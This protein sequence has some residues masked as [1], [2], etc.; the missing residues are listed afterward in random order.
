MNR[1]EQG[2]VMPLE[3]RCLYPGRWIIEGY[4]VYQ[5]KGRRA[6]NWQS[7]WHVIGHPGVIRRTLPE[8]RDWIREQ[9]Q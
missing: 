9:A 2:K 3:Q 8:I 1:R 6:V 7:E 4:G 5:R